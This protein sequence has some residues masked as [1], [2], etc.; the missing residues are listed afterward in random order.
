MTGDKKKGSAPTAIRTDPTTS[1]TT[2]QYMHA[3]LGTQEAN[4]Y[5]EIPRL[6]MDAHDTAKALSISERTLWR[7]TSK[8]EIPSVRI[9]RRVLYDPCALQR[10]IDGEA[11]VLESVQIGD[12][13]SMVP[14]ASGAGIHIEGNVGAII[15]QNAGE[16]GNFMHIKKST[17]T[18]NNRPIKSA[19]GSDLFLLFTFTAVVIILGALASYD[20]R[21]SQEFFMGLVKIVL[22]Q[23]PVI[24]R[25]AKFFA[26]KDKP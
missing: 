15:V 25:L 26:R 7:L 2:R 6:L 18:G 4:T 8:G 10:W 14:D 11:G 5:R 22:D 19:L 12:G 16:G 20:E 17:G 13:K 9:G 23:L 3:P 24:G 21:L 1:S